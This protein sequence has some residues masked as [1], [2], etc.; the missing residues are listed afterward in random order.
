MRIC[1]LHFFFDSVSDFLSDF[2][3][4][5]GPDA[6]YAKPGNEAMKM[7]KNFDPKCFTFS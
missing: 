6:N 5:V 2:R 4:F 1:L 3:A 7:M